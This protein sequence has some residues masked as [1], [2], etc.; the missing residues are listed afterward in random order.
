MYVKHVDLIKDELFLSVLFQ[1]FFFLCVI[2]LNLLCKQDKE[3]S[4]TPKMWV[5]VLCSIT[6]QYLCEFLFLLN[7]FLRLFSQLIQE[8]WNWR[9]LP[10]KKTFWA[11]PGWWD[12][13]QAWRWCTCHG[14]I[15]FSNLIYLSFWIQPFLVA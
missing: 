9:E 10:S 11:S 5:L 1:I 2:M 6:F 8:R 12:Y 13:V 15:Y 14:N 4:N 3:T 7:Y